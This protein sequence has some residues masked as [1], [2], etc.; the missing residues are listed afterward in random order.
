MGHQQINDGGISCQHL[1]MPRIAKTYDAKLVLGGTFI[2][3]GELSPG[4]HGFEIDSEE[5]SPRAEAK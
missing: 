2:L 5:V 4:A 3:F 1:A